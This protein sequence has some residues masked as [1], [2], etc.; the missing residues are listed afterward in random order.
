[1]A[2]TLDDLQ[3]ILEDDYYKLFSLL[4]TDRDSEFEKYELFEVNT[5]TGEIRSNIFY[6]DPQTPSQ[7][8]HVEN[9]HNYVRDIIPNGKSLKKFNARRFEFNV[10]TYQLCTKKIIK[11]QNSL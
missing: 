11:W 9:N 3:V 5:E 2:I 10:F 1:M 4:L 6:C 7:K 8:P